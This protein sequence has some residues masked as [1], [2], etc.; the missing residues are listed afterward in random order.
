MAD[1]TLVIGKR[2]AAKQRIGE[3]GGERSTPPRSN[4]E[5]RTQRG[6]GLWNPA[7]RRHEDRRAGRQRFDGRRTLPLVGGKRILLI[8]TVK[9]R[10][11]T[12]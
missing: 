10:T 11:L 8:C 6:N 5:I 9:S 7:D 3:R 4:D 1:A 2:D 12:E